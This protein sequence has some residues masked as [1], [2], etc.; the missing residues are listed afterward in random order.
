MKKFLSVALAALCAAAMLTSCA[1]EKAKGTTKEAIEENPVQEVATAFTTTVEKTLDSTPVAVINKVADAGNVHFKVSTTVQGQKMSYDV[2]ASEGKDIKGAAKVSAMGIDA[3]IYVDTKALVVECDK[4]LGNKAYG[5]GFKD[6]EKNLRSSMLPSMMGIDVDELL[7]EAGPVIE[8]LENLGEYEKQLTAFEKETANTFFEILADE[9][10]YTATEEMYE[11]KDGQVD[12]IVL[13]YKVTPELIVEA[14]SAYIDTYF[15]NPLV[16]QYMNILAAMEG[17]SAEAIKDEFVYEA[18]DEFEYEI[19]DA[20][21]EIGMDY[22]PIT[23]VFNK[24]TGEF[25]YA[26]VMNDEGEGLYIDLGANPNKSENWII[27]FV[28]DGDEGQIVI[29]KKF[30]GNNGVFAISIEDEEVMSFELNGGKYVFEVD[31]YE[32]ATGTCKYSANSLE[33]S[34]DGIVDGEDLEFVIDTQKT[35]SAPSFKD[36][37]KMSMADFQNVATTIQKN[38]MS[39]AGSMGG[40]M[41]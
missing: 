23:V 35:P 11:L 2:W 40:M 8:I 9:K 15:A 7:E 3:T 33:F 1:G 36:L 38:A 31:G 41:Y 32:M 19:Y 20:F 21:D 17:V 28:E 18:L 22:F 25:V 13:D 4:L 10:N 26:E 12:A 27:G 30:N 14:V 5:I 37:L 16:A 29:T 24:K 6:I 34:I 39:I